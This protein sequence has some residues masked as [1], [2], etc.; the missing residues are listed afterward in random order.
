MNNTIK[1]TFEKVSIKVKK[2]S[3]EILVV[4]GVVGFVMSGVM[5][6]HATTKISTILDEAKHTIDSIHECSSDVSMEEEYTKDDAK[7]DLAIT[8]VQTGVKLAKLYAPAITIGTLSIVSVL[9]SNNVLRK[10]NIAIAAAYTAMDKTFKDY[11]GRVV[12]R[13]GEEVDKE[14]RCNIKAK[15]FEK[16]VTDPETGKEKKIKATTNVANPVDDYTMFFDETFCAYDETYDYNL[17]SLRAT[18]TYFN[19]VLT[20]RGY[21]FLN[22][23]FDRLGHPRTKMGQVVGWVYRPEDKSRDSFVDFGIVETNRETE[24]G[25]YEKAI[26]LNFNVDG[27]ILELI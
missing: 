3:P 14:L 18:E 2:H 4:S 20:A 15:K 13:F 16:N 1:T 11:R 27:P 21:V 25:Y 19:N 7:K 10:R 5:A 26:L 24:D 23:V 9:A 12:E 8:Y 6:C 17:S 22:D